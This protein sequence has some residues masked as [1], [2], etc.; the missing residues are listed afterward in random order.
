[1]PNKSLWAVMDEIGGAAG[2]SGTDAGDTGD[3]F[4]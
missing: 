4:A 1:M 2:S 3:A